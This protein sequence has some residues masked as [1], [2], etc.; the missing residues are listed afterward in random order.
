MLLPPDIKKYIA[1]ARKN[2]KTDD[3]I[4][5]ALIEAGWPHDQAESALGNDEEEIKPPP[6][7]PPL[8][9]TS[10]FHMWDTF[11][12]I[13]LFVSL[14][15]LA[16]AINFILSVYIDRWLP[17]FQYNTF[18]SYDSTLLYNSLSAI[19]VTYPLFSFFFLDIEKRNIKNKFLHNLK[20]RKFLI[21]ITLIITFV[22]ML[23]SI[24]SIISNF[25]NGEVSN[26]ALAHFLV[27][28]IIFGVIFTYYLWQV[29]QDKRVYA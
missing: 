1:Y 6:Y 18:P 19:I 23:F 7:N 27:T 12:N 17:K 15:V 21:Y 24:I 2:N 28:I 14:F 26:N 9:V 11:E 25:L 10:A 29:I 16:T 4:K 3:E 20:S 8:P 22:I 13:L 5:S